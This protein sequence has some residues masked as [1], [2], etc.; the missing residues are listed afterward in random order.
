MSRKTIAICL[1][2]VLIVVVAGIGW[3]AM[4]SEDRAEQAAPVVAE[5]I[6]QDKTTGLSLR[7][8]EPLSQSEVSSQDKKDKFIFRL[9]STTPAMLVSVR[10]EDGL[11]AV[12][13]VSR[14]ELLPMLLTNADKSFPQ[15]YSEYSKKQERQ[16]EVAGKK[17]AELIFTYKG[18][19]GDVAKQRL[20]IIAKDE[21]TAIYISA[22]TQ[23]PK[24]SQ[25]NDQYFESLFDSV[26]FDS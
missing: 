21:D 11:R 9:T 18:P 6:A 7:Y 10:Y 13:A 1:V 19:N 16:L 15:R 20:L 2:C 3:L 12:T 8:K 25:L 14:Q 22:Q 23:E 5:H 4:S 24:F 26:T 17:A